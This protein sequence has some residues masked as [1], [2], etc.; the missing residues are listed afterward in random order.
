MSDLFHP[1]APE[2]FIDSVF[3]VIRKTERHT[4]QVLTKRSALMKEYFS[5]HACPKNCWLGVSVED[6]AHG[7]PRIDDLRNIDAP[8]RFLSCEPLLED[9]GKIDLTGINWVIVGGE[10]GLKA[11]PMRHEWVLNILYQTKQAGAAF[12]FKQWGTWGDDGMKRSK[13]KNGALLEGREWK[14]YP[15]EIHHEKNS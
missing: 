9:L 1:D 2:Y 5:K 4:Y 8:V 3:D 14:E 11:R 6:K 13:A 10:S 12:F 7:L 15:K